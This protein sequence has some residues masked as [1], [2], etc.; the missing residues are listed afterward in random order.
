M[1]KFEFIALNSTRKGEKKY[2]KLYIFIAT[3]RL[4]GL[5]LR[6]VDVSPLSQLVSSS[7]LLSTP[8]VS[9]RLGSFICYLGGTRRD[10]TATIEMTIQV[11]RLLE[12][13]ESSMSLYLTSLLSL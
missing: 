2:Y 6:H 13:N 9:T 12:T 11:Y 5:S 10:R 3:I 4:I 8:L 1:Y 7:K